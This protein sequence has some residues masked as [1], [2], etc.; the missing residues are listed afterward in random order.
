MFQNN[1]ADPV[2]RSRTQHQ[3]SPKLQDLPVQQAFQDLFLFLGSYMPLHRLLSQ[4]EPR[5]T[6]RAPRVL[7]AGKEAHLLSCK[8]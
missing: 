7:A 4:G 2:V 8:R 6:L 3:L 5:V 1:V